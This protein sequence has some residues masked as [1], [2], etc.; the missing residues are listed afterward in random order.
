MK[1]GAGGGA[2]HLTPREELPTLLIAAG[3]LT[4]R[5]TKEEG[6]RRMGM[7]PEGPD[8]SLLALSGR[9]GSILLSTRRGLPRPEKNRLTKA[10]G[11][12]MGMPSPRGAGSLFRR[13]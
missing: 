1:P 5:L 7:K 10:E 12:Y 11:P 9:P 13:R 4:P 6:A 2:C 8:N 3:P